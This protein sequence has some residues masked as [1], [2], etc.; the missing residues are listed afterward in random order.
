MMDH[1]KDI[2]MFK[3]EAAKKNDPL[4]QY[5]NETLPTLQKH[6]DGAKKLEQN[7]SASR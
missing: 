5:A 3:R 1:K 7:K 4:A 6:L 2:A